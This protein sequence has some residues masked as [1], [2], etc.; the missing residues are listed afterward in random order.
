MNKLHEAFVF[1]MK[2]M[3]ENIETTKLEENLKKRL[4]SLK[5]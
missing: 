1:D 3:A 5:N 4:L 2:G